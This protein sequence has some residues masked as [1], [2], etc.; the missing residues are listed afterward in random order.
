[1]Y[2]FIFEIN[3]NNRCTIWCQI[4]NFP[5]QL[6]CH[7]VHF[8]YPPNCIYYNWQYTYSFISRWTNR[9]LLQ[10]YKVSS[11]SYVAIARVFIWAIDQKLSITTHLYQACTSSYTW[12]CRASSALDIDMQYLLCR[13]PP[14]Q[15]TVNKISP[16]C[17]VLTLLRCDKGRLILSIHQHQDCTVRW[18]QLYYSEIITILVEI[19]GHGSVFVK[20]GCGR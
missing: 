12:L 5:K 11:S 18:R 3:S 2:I 4:C 14:K 8:I 9:R 20:I 10:L 19:N 6:L 1:M 13:T 16:L 15:S 7:M 17:F